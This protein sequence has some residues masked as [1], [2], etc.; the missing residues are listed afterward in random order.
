MSTVD[1]TVQT[2]LSPDRLPPPIIE[3][4]EEARIVPVEQDEGLGCGVFRPDGSFCELSRTRISD[5]RFTAQ[6]AL[7]DMRDAARLEGTYLFGGLGRHHFGHFLMESIARVWAMDGRYER[8]DGL[9]M[10]PFQQTDFGSVLRRRLLAFFEIMGVDMPL[11]LVKVPL[12]AERLLIP[13]QGFGHQ[14]WASGTE[15]FRTYVRGRIAANCPAQGPE[16]IYISRSKLKHGHQKVDQEERIE[17]MMRAAGY[18]IF[19]P[20]RHSIAAQIRVYRAAKVIVG[21]D[22]SAF[23][24]VPFAMREGAR[25]GLIQRR[26]RDRAVQAIA[27]QI[28]AFEKVKL[29]RIDALTGTARHS[30]LPDPMDIAAL[31]AQLSETGFI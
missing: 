9:I 21:G 8:F 1:M 24:M 27:N 10:L 30:G 7:P 20:Q 16:K 3:P 2:P 5:D 19:H 28:T 15:E 4:V 23:H 11:H 14:D 31:Q 12:V 13:A 25:I 26:A 22:G 6:P 29:T 17:R 18:E